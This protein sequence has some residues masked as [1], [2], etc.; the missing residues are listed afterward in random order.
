M[1]KEFALNNSETVYLDEDL[2]LTDIDSEWDLSDKLVVNG[3]TRI[4]T[5]FPG[6][7]PEGSYRN[8]LSRS[9]RS[10]AYVTS[11]RIYNGT[12]KFQTEADKVIKSI[13]M[14]LG[15]S[16]KGTTLN[17]KDITKDELLA[18]V[19]VNANSAELVIEGGSSV[20]IFYSISY[21]L[22]DN[23]DVA[24]EAPAQTETVPVEVTSVGYATFSCDKALDLTKAEKIKA[25]TAKFTS[26]NVV[27]FTRIYQVPANTGLLLWAAG[28]ATENIPVIASA[29]SV[30]DNVLFVAEEDMT[31]ED[32]SSNGFYIL[33]SGEMGIGF[34]SAGI[35]S[36]LAKGKCYLFPPV[37]SPRIIMPGMEATSIGAS[38]VNSEKVNNGIFNLQGQRI[39][40]LQKGLNIVNGRKVVM[41]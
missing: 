41:K 18:G 26:D 13:K 39:S 28:G 37:S 34:Y 3:E 23:P 7:D 21:V 33:A 1:H 40:Q 35:G 12:I 4:T 6:S 38:L 25:Y 27:E 32:L 36:S 24:I 16:F 9:T 14:D 17:G 2:T 22:A 5:T 10:G 15:N 29:T 31:G 8:R 11:C 20:T 19:E 30:A